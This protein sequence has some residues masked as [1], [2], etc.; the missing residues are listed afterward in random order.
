MTRNKVEIASSTD[1]EGYLETLP[2]HSKRL[3]EAIKST[4][5]CIVGYKPT[6]TGWLFY[7]NDEARKQVKESLKAHKV[8][9]KWISK[10][11][12]A[13]K[14]GTI[15][16][17][18]KV[19]ILEV[20]NDKTVNEAIAYVHLPNAP[21]GSHNNSNNYNYLTEK[22][23]RIINQATTYYTESYEYVF[24]EGGSAPTRVETA[25]NMSYKKGNNIHFPAGLI[26]RVVIPSL[27][28]E[29]IIVEYNGNMSASAFFSD[30]QYQW[31]GEAPWSHQTDMSDIMTLTHRGVF[32]SA[33]GT[34]KTN[35]FALGISK[36]GL[37]TVV[38]VP[39]L[40]LLY[41]IA[42][43]LSQYY[44]FQ[45]IGLV[46]DTKCGYIVAKSMDNREFDFTSSDLT[47]VQIVVSTRQTLLSAVKRLP[48]VESLA[49]KEFDKVL[50]E[51]VNA[52]SEIDKREAKPLE[53]IFKEYYKGND[54][55]VLPMTKALEYLHGL[56]CFE[57]ELDILAGGG[58]TGSKYEHILNFV[59]DTKVIIIDECHS[60][61]APSYQ[62]I[63]PYFHS[64]QRIYGFSATPYTTD[65]RNM[66]IEAL[67]GA[68]RYIYTIRE[69]ME[70][71]ILM[72]PEQV[73]MLDELPTPDTPYEIVD[74][75]MYEFLQPH[76]YQEGHYVLDFHAD[77]DPRNKHHEV[78]FAVTNNEFYDR[79]SILLVNDWKKIGHV[80]PV[81][82]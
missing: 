30:F 31:H 12:E 14:D 8:D 33:T 44:G 20:S 24:G 18:F 46:G 39:N 68:R 66:E 21:V 10:T 22:V 62:V 50:K 6:A 59:K 64:L 55:Y 19:V 3:S 43:R 77:A 71:G 53:K 15:D 63:I 17:P 41:E 67:I 81:A 60:A 58:T 23:Y 38:I 32:E 4:D 48:D 76:E 2:H 73:M 70:D 79:I 80:S 16:E 27:E 36:L 61:S 45:K 25:H 7:D 57:K 51:V 69:A 72:N 28:K 1:E 74:A 26:E 13:E 54:K 9:A 49:K 47:D 29:N 65:G 11:I 37:K 75:Q 35:A 34:G 42:V 40:D 52:V 5:W 82:N 56:G 78:K